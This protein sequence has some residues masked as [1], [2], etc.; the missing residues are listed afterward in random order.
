MYRSPNPVRLALIAAALLFA[1]LPALAQFPDDIPENAR[2]RLGGIFATL[3]SKATLSTANLPGTVIDFSDLGL[4]PHHKTTFQGDGYWNFLGRSYLDFGYVDF[5]VSGS[6]SIAKD[7]SF[8]GVIYTAG[9]TVDAESRARFI[10][11][12]YRYG[13]FKN[14]TFHFGLSLGVSYYSARASLAATAGVTRP[15]GTV[16]G[17]GFTAERELNLPVPLIGAEAE[18]RL[19]SGVTL[20]ARFRGVKAT[21]APYSGTWVEAQGSINWYFARNFGIGGAY[22][23]HKIRIEKSN[24][25]S[26]VRFDQLYDGPRG[27]LVITF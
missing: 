27:F 21:V 10:Y 13:I 24:A 16:I 15:D 8:G 3:D 14:P 1:S 26:F 11:A 22:D 7:I 23:Y 5:D 17:G 18:L 2:F 9:A 20:G 19:F 25:T 6:H 12:A 4:T